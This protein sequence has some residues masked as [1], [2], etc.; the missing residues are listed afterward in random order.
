MTIN[1]TADME[2]IIAEQLAT[3]RYGSV[4]EVL[5][6]SLRLLEEHEEWIEAEKPAIRRKIAEGMEQALRGELFDGEQVFRRLEAQ[7]RERSGEP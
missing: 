1:L 7:L 3:G 6:E 4:E 2:R 5:R